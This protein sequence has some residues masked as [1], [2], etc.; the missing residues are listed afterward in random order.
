[1]LH[2]LNSS[3]E[4]FYCFCR[5]VVSIMFAHPHNK[6]Q[7]RHQPQ[8]LNDFSIILPGVCQKLVIGLTDMIQ[9]LQ[10]IESCAFIHKQIDLVAKPQKAWIFIFLRPL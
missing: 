1:M 4:V 2:S 6:K 9:M 7:N 5:I 3:L 10:F 8:G